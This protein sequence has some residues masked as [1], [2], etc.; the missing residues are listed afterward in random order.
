MTF[1]G[2][3]CEKD[4]R[5]VHRYFFPGLRRRDVRGEGQH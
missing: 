2:A 4:R 3:R 5:R 1:V